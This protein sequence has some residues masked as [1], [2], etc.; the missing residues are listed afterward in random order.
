MGELQKNLP[1]SEMKWCGTLVCGAR[2]SKSIL[3]QGKGGGPSYCLLLSVV[4][5]IGYTQTSNSCSNL[6]GNVSAHC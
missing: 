5:S 4:V 6:R 3:Y 1:V 2:P